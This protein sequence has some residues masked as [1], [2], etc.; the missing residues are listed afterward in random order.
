VRD[1]TAANPHAAR[2]ADQVK[3]LAEAGWTFARQAG[4]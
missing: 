1:G 4:A 3:P 2:M